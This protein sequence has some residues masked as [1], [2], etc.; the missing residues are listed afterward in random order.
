MKKS[1]TEEEQ[2]YDGFPVSLL[3]G[4]GLQGLVFRDGWKYRDKCSADG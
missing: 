3:R 1:E 4:S 2:R